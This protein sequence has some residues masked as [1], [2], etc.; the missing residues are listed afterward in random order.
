MQNQIMT[1]SAESQLTPAPAEKIREAVA[2]VFA[3]YPAYGSAE[4]T[5]SAIGTY[6]AMLKE[7]PIK[8][9]T[10]AAQAFMSG[11]VAGYNPANR[12]TVAQW[13]VEACS[14]RDAMRAAAMPLRALPPPEREI[15]PDERAAVEKQFKALISEMEAKEP[16]QPRRHVLTLEDDLAM[17]RDKPLTISNRFHTLLQEQIA[18]EAEARS[19]RSYT[20]SHQNDERAA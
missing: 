13:S 12:P 7:Y 14:R 6:A 18:E 10:D 4:A 15:P 5:E 17:T 9:I 3:A 16:R 19:R 8:A 20:A 11:R 1:T 2:R